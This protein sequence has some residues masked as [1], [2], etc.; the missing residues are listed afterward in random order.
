M[1]SPW[2]FSPSCRSLKGHLQRTDDV[3]CEDLASVLP[4]DCFTQEFDSFSLDNSLLTALNYIEDARENGE[5]KN[6]GKK[7]KMKK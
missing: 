5:W 3:L 2:L 4:S 7:K 6:L 1:P